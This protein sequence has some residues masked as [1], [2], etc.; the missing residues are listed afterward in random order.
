[1]QTQ[2]KKKIDFAGKELYIGLDVHKKSW[3]VTVLSK[4][5]CLHSFTQPP[6]ASLLNTYLRTQFSGANYHSAYE[7]GFCG[8][9]HHRELVALGIDIFVI[10]SADIQRTNKDTVT[11]NDKRDS[12]MIAEALRSGLLKC[13]HIF[14]PQSE[15]FRALFRSPLALAKD[16]RKTRGRMGRLFP[17]KLLVY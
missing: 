7:A 13:I 8:Y 1:M 3:Q 6:G 10:N 16:I 15:E 17:K 12:R 14:G 4:N 2:I 9:G 11:K 5:I